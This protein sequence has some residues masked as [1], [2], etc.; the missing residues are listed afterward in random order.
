MPVCQKKGQL[1]RTES[2]NTIAFLSRKL[3]PFPLPID[4]DN[5]RADYQAGEGVGL[6][7]S[8]DAFKCIVRYNII[9]CQ[10]QMIRAVTLIHTESSSLIYSIDEIYREQ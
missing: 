4:L 6:V 1:S 9:V 2:V 5:I 8:G 7:D 10:I 3:M